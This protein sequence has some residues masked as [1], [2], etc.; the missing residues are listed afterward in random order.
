VEPWIR[1]DDVLAAGTGC[2]HALV[3]GVSEYDHL[4]G[5]GNTT[6]FGLLPLRSAAASAWAFARWLEQSY[7]NANAPLATVR[8]L[9]APSQDEMTQTPELGALPA[10]V[11]EPSAQAVKTALFDWKADCD[12]R[13][14]NVAILYVAGHGIMLS[15]DEGGILLLKDFAAPNETVLAGSLD[16]PSVRRGLAGP[17]VAQHQFFF[18]DA[19][20]V[21][22]QDVR[23]VLLRGGVGLDEPA[24]APP[25][26][27]AV[28]TSAAPGT[29]ALGAPGRGT[30]FSQALL[31]CL[32][33]LGTEP[34]DEGHWVVTDTSLVGPLKARVLELAAESGLEQ[35]ATGGGVLGP[36][37]LHQL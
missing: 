35:S 8:L 33:L 20:Q 28:Y 4:P 29:L 23:D 34:D 2:T 7:A 26:V 24:E 16:V 12:A 9:L 32:E 37:V 6:T 13:P 11:G 31:E 25:A 1:R 19:C 14:E 21:R 15:K 5:D 36:V 30:L 27:S 18:I 3:V 22:P 17:N 10:T